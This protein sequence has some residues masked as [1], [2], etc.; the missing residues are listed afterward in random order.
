MGIL[1]IH[2]HVLCNPMHLSWAGGDN[3]SPHTTFRWA[4][5]LFSK[6]FFF[7]TLFKPNTSCDLRLVWHVRNQLSCALCATC[8]A[9]VSQASLC[10][11][12]LLVCCALQ[13]CAAFFVEVCENTSFKLCF[14]P[15]LLSAVR[16]ARSQ[17]SWRYRTAIGSRCD[18]CKL[19]DVH[20]YTLEA[21]MIS[22]SKSS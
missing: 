1:G 21:F 13:V 3:I 14:F 11:R 7:L 4:D 5:L 18:W 16:L 8:R 6:R 19:K 17:T 9:Y 12:R 10:Q 2:S 15:P 20:G 22:S